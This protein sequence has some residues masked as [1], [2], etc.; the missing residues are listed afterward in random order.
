MV[1]SLFDKALVAALVVL[2]AFY[3]ALAFIR[4]DA[5]QPPGDVERWRTKALAKQ[6]ASR[7][8]PAPL[9]QDYVA[10]AVGAIRPD[11]VAFEP[12]A[13][14][15]GGRPEVVVEDP[16]VPIV[17]RI[18]AEGP[19]PEPVERP[20]PE[21]VAGG[22][23]RVGDEAVARAQW[24]RPGVLRVEGVGSGQTHV[25]VWQGGARR[26]RIEVTVRAVPV[27]KPMLGPPGGFGVAQGQ[28]QVE[29]TWGPAA[30]MNAVVTEYRIYKGEGEG[31]LE[32]YIRVPV[33]DE[34]GG[35]EALPVLTADGT[36]AEVAVTLRGDQF[37]LIDPD[38]AGGVLYRY[39]ADAVGRDEEGN[40]L[41]SEQIGP[42]SVEVEEPFRIEFYTRAPDAIAVAV[43]VF[44]TDEE[45]GGRW[46]KH[47]FGR[48]IR[49][50]D[51]VGWRVA[52]VALPGAREKLTNV[53][54]STGYVVL[55]ILNGERRIGG[56]KEIRDAAGETIELQQREETQ[57]KVLLI[58]ER[59]RIKSLWPSVRG[60]E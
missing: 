21:S 51:P 58:D 60:R 30:V 5:I 18:P 35:E 24:A 37:V 53:D 43:S 56:Q 20:L 42:E 47:T 19:P 45:G 9:T 2:V 36:R 4:P 7:H 32:L 52:E 8:D 23:I 48:G 13:Y 11:A 28:G 15:F 57:Q 17:I 10:G 50:G 46:V 33:P 40:E 34:P 1:F 54:F 3:I 22:E 29:V 38:V 39:A 6:K 14:I 16:W 27:A 31:P 59:G 55:D 12:R 26:G 25:E 49:R 41:V 44:H